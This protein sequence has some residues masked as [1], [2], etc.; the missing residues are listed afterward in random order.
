MINEIG[1]EKDLIGGWACCQVNKA[2]E[3]RAAV[4]AVLLPLSDQISL[5][6]G[7]PKHGLFQAYCV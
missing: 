3:G 7:S 4:W 1:D 2:A 5:K 6:V